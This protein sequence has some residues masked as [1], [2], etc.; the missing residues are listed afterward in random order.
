MFYIYSTH[1]P[2]AA[3]RSRILYSRR[4]AFF[5]F[6]NGRGYSVTVLLDNDDDGGDS[7]IL[8]RSS[9]TDLVAAV[10][11]SPLTGSPMRKNPLPIAQSSS[12]HRSTRLGRD[13]KLTNV[14]V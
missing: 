11:L 4:D 5:N 3:D 10:L 12:S 9:L 7:N 2:A 14:V 8:F 1:T 6:F 13:G